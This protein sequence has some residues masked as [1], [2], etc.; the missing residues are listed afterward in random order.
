M[1]GGGALAVD[2]IT[3]IIKKAPDDS[4]LV[5]Q[6]DSFPCRWRNSCLPKAGKSGD[7]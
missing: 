7:F 3:P 4:L 1:V 6:R 5:F 2:L